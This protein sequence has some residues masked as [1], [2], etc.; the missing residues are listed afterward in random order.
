M[1]L[2]EGSEKVSIS[3]LSDDQLDKVFGGGSSSDAFDVLLA[4]GSGAIEL[5]WK[6]RAA[7]LYT[8]IFGSVKAGPNGEGDYLPHGSLDNPFGS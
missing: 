4:E 2:T 8:L 3:E 6:E 7:T 5:T 1:K